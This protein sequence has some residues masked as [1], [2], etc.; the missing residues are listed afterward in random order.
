VD[1]A[2]EREKCRG[3]GESMSSHQTSLRVTA[4]QSLDANRFSEERLIW[5]PRAH[6][7]KFEGCKET[8]GIACGN[9][10]TPMDRK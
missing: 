2:H 10:Q 5:N 3:F 4:S 7:R 6:A 8:I 9:L 1:A